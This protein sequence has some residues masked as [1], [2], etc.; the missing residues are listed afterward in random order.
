[1]W[2]TYDA[3]R[4]L[5]GC[6]L[7]FLRVRASGA[8]I[9]ASETECTDSVE[10]ESKY[11]SSRKRNKFPY[12]IATRYKVCRPGRSFSPQRPHVR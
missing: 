9:P 10:P 5:A 6:K 1:M 12:A 3:E 8:D 7:I 4:T 11:L 2:T